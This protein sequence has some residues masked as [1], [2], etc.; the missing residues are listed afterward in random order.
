MQHAPRGKWGGG[1]GFEAVHGKAE[2]SLRG[3]VWWT[4]GAGRGSA[5][6]GRTCS[7]RPPSTAH[8]QMTEWTG[9][10]DHLSRPPGRPLRA[11]AS[12]LT[13]A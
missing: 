11:G 3:T 12:S 5:S 2:M 10:N 1:G 6:P 9:P 8:A 7:F 4:G 13:L